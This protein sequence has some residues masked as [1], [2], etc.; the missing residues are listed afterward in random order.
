MSNPFEMAGKKAIVVGGSRGIGRSIVEGLHAC[1][2]EV[3]VVGTNDHVYEVAKEVGA[4]GAP[5]HG[6]KGDVGARETREGIFNEC[7]KALGGKLDILINNAGVN[8]RT[9]PT[10]EYAYEDYDRTMAVNVESVFYF[11]Q[12]AARMM[13]PQGHGKI[14]NI[15]STAALEGLANAVIYSASKHAVIGLTK[16]LAREWS[17]H[18]LRINSVAPGFTAT[19][20]AKESLANPERM[21]NVYSS[22]PVG[23]IAQPDDIAGAVLFLA[24]PASDYLTGITI[25][26]DGGAT[27]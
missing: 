5:V 20:L 10:I 12:F 14:I 7:V 13:I 27:A 18:G 4:S 11:C 15:S 17:K 2:V 23:E 25:P 1:G 16:S 26:V 8:I 21:K 3:A 6:V 24:S 22:L 19:D 9:H